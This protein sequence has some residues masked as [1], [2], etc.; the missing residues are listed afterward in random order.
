MT[1][2]NNNMMKSIQFYTKAIIFTFLFGISVKYEM[3][4][5][6]KQFWGVTSAGGQY[7]KGTIFKTDSSGNNQSMQYNFVVQ[8][9]GANPL[10][11]QLTEASDGKLYGMT[12]NGGAN[13][14]GVLFQY[15]PATSTY[16]KKLDFAGA[17][18]GQ[19]PRGS[20]MQASD[21]KLYGMTYQGGSNNAGVLFQYDPATSNYTKKLDFAGATNGAY[22]CGSLMQA[23]DGKLYGMTAF[24]G[25][26]GNGVLFQYDPA[27]SS[28][29]KKL[30]FAG[31]TNGAQPAGSLMQASDGKL[32]GMNQNGGANNVGVLFQYDPATSTYTKKL[33]FGTTNGV[34]P[35]GSLMEANDGKLYGMTLGGGANNMG[36][37]FQY[38]AATSSFTKKLD[39]AG[40]TNGANPCGSLMQA[41]DG[42]LY[43]L[44]RNGGTNNVGVLFQYD[45]ATSTYTKNLD[46]AGAINGSNSE[47]SP[48]QASDG[49]LYGMTRYGGANN[50][51]VLFQ[52][53]L[54][55]STYT[56]KFDFAGVTNGVNPFGSLMQANDGKLYGMTYQGGSSNTGVLYQYD[57]ATSNYTKKL[58]FA[59]A[60]NGANPKGSLIQASDGKFYG[61]TSGGGANNLGVL[62]QYDP[63]TSNYTKKLDFAGATNG[64]NPKGSLMQAS[65]GKLYGMTSTG[66]TNNMGV[67][68]QY[69]P[70]TSTY[71]KTFDFAGATN[72]TTPAGSLIQASDGKLYGMTYGGGV[73]GN[74]VLFQYDP[75]TSTYIKKL[76]FDGF[77]YGSYPNGSLIQASNGKLYGM[78]FQGGASNLGVLFQYDPTTSTCTKKLDFAGATNGAN[79]DG[80]L[81]Q[82]SNGKLYGMTSYGGTNNKGVLFQ[83]DPATSTYSKTLDFAGANGVNP[84]SDLIEITVLASSSATVCFG[85]S[86][87]LTA[88]GASTYSWSTGATTSTISVTPTTNTSYTVTGTAASGYSSTAIGTVTVNA[89]P[90][91]SLVT[92]SP[93]CI[94]G[95]L[96][97]LIGS[98]ANGTYTGTGV[99][100]SSFN[101]AVSGAGIFNVTYSYTDVN[102]CSSSA[103]QSASVGL[104]TGITEVLNESTISIYPNPAH[105]LLTLE[106]LAGNQKSATVIIE[107]MFGQVIYETQMNTT[108]YQINTEHYARGIYLIKV[109]SNNETI[110]KKIILE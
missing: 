58:D 33:D 46:F 18:N 98:P 38:D 70:A 85:S 15:D 3:Q 64:A 92:I 84:Y 90:V 12:S 102:N 96:V 22:P 8:N 14:M 52:Y 27:T 95:S 49:K 25:S 78:A 31:A 59:G 83:Y 24:G 65:D 81:M 41:S 63:A 16:S 108:T 11:N 66:G 56:K 99:S 88:S 80:S 73:N 30:D 40:A 19:S 89:L 97:T 44:T 75:A 57:P 68:F 50:V 36:V 87:V 77:T 6:T 7:G 26:S 32:Y 72:G 13:N 17:T 91:V 67:L 55:T 69:D 103:S 71:A 37:L 100:G 9:E 53:D 5:Q 28:Y 48:M 2:T 104:C 109:K 60:T 94:N 54:A 101:P 1:I 79:P 43:G 93:M 107:N 51:G 21:G 34:S 45:P 42:K 4:A 74:G 29:T 61:M 23:S 86:V 20:L 47:G 110:T 82:A 10:S 105:D 62:F 106:F 39:F 76:D 35:L